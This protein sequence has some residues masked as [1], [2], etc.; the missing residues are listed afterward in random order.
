MSGRRVPNQLTQLGMLG[1]SPAEKDDGSTAPQTPLDMA[2]DMFMLH[3]RASQHTPRTLEFYEYTLSGFLDF[4]HDEGVDTP[5]GVQR[6]HIRQFI[7]HKQ[8]EGCKNATVHGYARAIKTFFNFL[9][10]EEVLDKTPMKN[11]AMPKLNEKVPP[12]FTKEEV[13]ALLNACHGHLALRD[14]AIILCLL[15]TGLRANEFSSLNVGD[16]ERDTGMVKVYGKGQKERYVRLGY[17]ARKALL[18]YLMERA[19]L[20]PDSPLW[21]GVRGDRLSRHGVWERIA[22]LGKRAGVHAHPH[23]FRRTFAIW[24]LR[25]G[26]DVHHLRRL[27]GHADLQMATRYLDMVQEDI[28]ESHRR[29]SPVDNMLEG[30]S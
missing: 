24:A 12:A 28:R 1:A 4:L 23:K 11:V 7:V 9:V 16:V 14:R 21:L 19:E 15:D 17:A 13:Q 29:A 22:Q 3:Q 18:R 8:D 26:M 2:R 10:D 25:G 6:H 5:Q 27:M 20:R 30:D